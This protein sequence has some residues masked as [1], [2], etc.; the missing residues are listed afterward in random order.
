[1]ST[2]AHLP[3][4]STPEQ[5][6]AALLPDV[7]APQPTPRP[8]PMRSLPAPS[9]LRRPDPE[10][11][12]LGTARLDRS[13]RIHER[14][15][16]RALGWGPGHELAINTVDEMIV[17]RSVP[18]GRHRIDDRR[19]LAL[20]AAV[21]RMCGIAIGPPVVLVAAVPEQTVL[22]HPAITVT[23]LLA[24]HHRTLIGT[25]DAC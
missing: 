25:H 1:M 7:T 2:R 14:T 12:L 5:L 4:P 13:G 3:H 21:R 17:I 20:P 10:T 18:G 15:L 19:A 11:L 24:A 9:P 22:I 8:A 6:I 23:R 16:F